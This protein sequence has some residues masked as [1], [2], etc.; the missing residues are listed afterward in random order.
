MGKNYLLSAAEIVNLL[1][2]QG[3][4]FEIKDLSNKVLVVEIKGDF[5]AKEFLSR[6]GGTVKVGQIHKGELNSIDLAGLI[7]KDK[8][9]KINFGFS[10]YAKENN[11]KS[12][13][14]EDL[15]FKIKDLSINLKKQLKSKGRSCRWVVSREKNLSSVVVKTNKLIETGAEIVLLV[16]QR[17]IL[18]GQTL[19]VQE[20]EEYSSR[21][22]GR[23]YRDAKSGMIPP[24]LAK[25]MINLSGADLAGTILDP[26]C[27]SGT[28]LQ[29]ALLV[30]YSKVVGSD[31]SEKAVHDSRKNLEWL[32]MK[33]KVP[34]TKMQVPIKNQV[35][36]H[37]NQISSKFQI[38][39][40]IPMSNDQ[41]EVHKLDVAKLSNKFEANSIDAVVT[42]P[43]LGPSNLK[44]A[45]IKRTS[46]LGQIKKELMGLYMGAFEEFYKILK[47]DGRV[48]MVWPVWQINQNRW[49]GQK[50]DEGL[51]FLP[52][53]ERMTKLG[54][55]KVN[56]L[57]KELL[58]RYD[59]KMNERKSLIYS[60]PNQTVFR[61]IWVWQK[62]AN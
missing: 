62:K 54:F 30:G 47:A 6:L 48:V 55:K 41:F 11:V 61:E 25:I 60:R 15:R 23:E 49:Q 16:G 24:K 7:S 46:E 18:V 31:I 50:P 2:F 36:N 17:E 37:K 26:F 32:I 43:Y 44:H 59:I 40:Q 29:E 19:A 52:L 12:K 51:S 13:R 33:Y 38:K 39:S 10:I 20:F 45:K 27:G 14:I 58:K 53:I 35:P 9:G 34:R 21:D 8:Q 22:Y 1:G 42:E 28:V 3:K 4:K 56:L 57:P 5:S